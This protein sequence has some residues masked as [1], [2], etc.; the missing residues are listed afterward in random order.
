MTNVPINRIYMTNESL[1]QL[2][3]DLGQLELHLKRQPFQDD[4]IA[5][6]IKVEEII[7]RMV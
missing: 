6:V 2:H 1:K 3:Y 5:A 4:E 7:E